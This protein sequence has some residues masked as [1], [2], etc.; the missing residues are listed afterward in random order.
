MNRKQEDNTGSQKRSGSALMG[1]LTLISVVC[2]LALIVMQALEF[3]KY[4]E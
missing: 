4:G 2:F 3:M 1:V